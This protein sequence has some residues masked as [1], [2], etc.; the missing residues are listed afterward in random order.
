M[1]WDEIVPPVAITL[2]VLLVAVACMI[3]VAQFGWIFLFVFL[4]FGAVGGIIIYSVKAAGAGDYYTG[5]ELC[6]EDDMDAILVCVGFT[7]FTLVFAL[8]YMVFQ[9]TTNREVRKNFFRQG[10]LIPN[11]KRTREILEP[12]FD[13]QKRS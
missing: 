13:L 3:F 8:L 1:D 5:P 10:F 11:T 2:S 9:L 12:D 6:W 4:T 7:F